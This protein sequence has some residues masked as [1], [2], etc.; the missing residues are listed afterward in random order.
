MSP[1]RAAAYLASVPKVPVTADNALI[2]L[3][4]QS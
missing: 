3:L 1:A 2:C 4:P